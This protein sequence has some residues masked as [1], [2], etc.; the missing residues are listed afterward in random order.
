[1]P[2]T[3]TVTG[4][5][6]R[7]ELEPVQGRVS[8]L[9]ERLWVID[10]GIAWA[11]LAPEVELVNGAFSVELTATDTDSVPW[12]YRVDT[13]AGNWRLHVFGCCGSYGFRDLLED[14]KLRPPY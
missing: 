14:Q 6:T 7:R 10:Q 4:A 11:C 9:P 1:M 3:V 12:Y 13:P 8:F 2:R 5:F